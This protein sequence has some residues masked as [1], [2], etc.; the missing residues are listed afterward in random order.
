M[1]DFRR[2]TM[3]T[4]NETFWEWVEAELRERDLTWHAVER[5]AG[6]SNAAISRRAKDRLRPTQTTADAIAKVF[7]IDPELVFRKAGLLPPAPDNELDVKEALHLFRQL[8]PVQ[9]Q[10]ML[11]QM[12]A[13]VER[14]RPIERRQS[15]ATG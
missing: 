3:K 4:R 6:L 7:N 12:R 5:K 8:S 1:L 13:L 9:R 15:A 11:I 14:E 2:E 10:V